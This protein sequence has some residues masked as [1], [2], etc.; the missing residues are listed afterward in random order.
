MNNANVTNV[1]QHT[2]PAQPFLKNVRG[3]RVERVVHNS[4][5]G[6]VTRCM[7]DKVPLENLCQWS[8]YSYTRDTSHR[9]V[10]LGSSS[11]ILEDGRVIHIREAPTQHPNLAAFTKC[12]TSESP[13][14]DVGCSTQTR[15]TVANGHSQII[16]DIRPEID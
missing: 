2:W 14:I 11:P 1:S 9:R 16:V 10:D 4:N 3:R 8:L 5:N 15:R 7:S 12:V 6:E 13:P